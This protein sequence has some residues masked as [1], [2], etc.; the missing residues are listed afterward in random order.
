MKK[1]ITILRIPFLRRRVTVEKNGLK[2]N[3]ENV[4]DNDQKHVSISDFINKELIHFSNNDILRSIP[5]ITDGFK[6]SQR[7]II[8]GCLESNL[9]RP[10]M[11]MKVSQISGKISSLT[12]YHHGEVSLQGAIINMAQNYM[13][14]NNISFLN[15][16]G[17][18]G[19]RLMSGND[20][21]SSR[22][23]FT[24]IHPV[25][26]YIIRKEDTCILKHNI[27]DGIKI[28]PMAYIPILPVVLLNGITGIGTGF[29]FQY[30][31]I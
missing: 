3:M 23:I 30:T 12:S 25:L 7:K 9:D 10:G 24:N 8:Y 19:T 14:S 21:A 28:E 13:G 29:F 27:E 1:W 2:Y 22:Y 26:K 6:P 5:N 4:L 17:Q 31:S 11:E 20:S 18:F 16:I 15:P